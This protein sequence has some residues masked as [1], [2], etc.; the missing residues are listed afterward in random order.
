[1]TRSSLDSRAV[2][3]QRK[4]GRRRNLFEATEPRPK[5]R[6]ITL[7]GGDG[8]EFLQ[9]QPVMRSLLWTM[10]TPGVC[11]AMWTASFCSAKVRTVPVSSISD[12]VML[13]WI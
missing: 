7:C 13:T 5:L 2:P 6:E 3:P 1:M 8:L 11:Q 9:I 12:P 4:S 10:V